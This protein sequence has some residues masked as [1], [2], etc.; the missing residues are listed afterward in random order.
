MVEE[1]RENELKNGRF[2]PFPSVS[3]LF[4]TIMEGAIPG[5]MDHSRQLIVKLERNGLIA[6]SQVLAFLAFLIP[7]LVL[8]VTCVFEG[9]Q[10]WNQSDSFLSYCYGVVTSAL[11]IF[12]Q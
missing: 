12:H 8:C 4:V 9:A 11:L 6:L 7:L 1:E 3:S 2:Q 5:F 10:R